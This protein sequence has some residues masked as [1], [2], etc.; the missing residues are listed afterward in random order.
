[1][2]TDLK[3]I[4]STNLGGFT[5]GQWKEKRKI[6]N[7]N[8]EYSQDWEEAINWY[9]NRLKVRYFNPLRKMEDTAKGEGFSLTTIHCAL[10][11]HFASIYHGKIHNEKLTK[12]SPNYQYLS[13]SKHFRNFL[14]TSNIFSEYFTTKDGTIPDFDAK[15]FYKNV[16]CALLHEACTK[17]EWRINT[18]SCGYSNPNNKIMVKDG[19]YIKRHY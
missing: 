18:I 5:I 10:I 15:D 2:N 1:M 11:E 6:L 7:S 4:D 16:R 3:T 17:N 9:D 13:S 12:S 8:L 19:K 14:E